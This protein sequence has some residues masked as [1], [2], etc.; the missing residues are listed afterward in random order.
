LKPTPYAFIRGS[1]YD[2]TLY[3]WFPALRCA[4]SGEQPVQLAAADA[5]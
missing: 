2:D 5:G 4:D 1:L 3:C